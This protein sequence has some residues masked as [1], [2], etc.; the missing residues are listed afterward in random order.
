[1]LKRHLAPLVFATLLKPARCGP[2]LWVPDTIT[3][4][5]QSGHPYGSDDPQGPFSVTI[6]DANS[7]QI[8]ETWPNTVA[9]SEGQWH[10]RLSEI[11]NPK[12]IHFEG[13]CDVPAGTKII[14][15]FKASNG[16]EAKGYPRTVQASNDVSCL[17]KNQGLSDAFH[18][19][20]DAKIASL[21]AA[22][23]TSTTS[24]P[25]PPVATTT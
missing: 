16:Q 8:L 2:W 3:Q 13:V 25:P 22:A 11:Q 5:A 23:T 14:F 24:S 17:G 6:N 18:S 15:D 10:C 9:N 21:Q 1:M 20:F 12:L 7:D 19:D 4:C